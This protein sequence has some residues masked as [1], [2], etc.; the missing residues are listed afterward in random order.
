MNLLIFSSIKENSK[1]SPL[2]LSEGAIFIFE[3]HF[4]FTISEL[5]NP[6]A[7]INHS[8]TAGFVALEGF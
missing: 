4:Q 7:L 5:S 6:P 8:F 3:K 1:G 2:V